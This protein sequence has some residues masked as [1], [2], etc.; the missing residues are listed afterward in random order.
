MGLFLSSTLK[1]KSKYYDELR[2]TDDKVEDEWQDEVKKTKVKTKKMKHSKKKKKKQINKFGGR[3]G[4]SSSS[5]SKTEQKQFSINTTD[6]KEMFELLERRP[7][8]AD[9]IVEKVSK[10][11]TLMM[12]TMVDS[13]KDFVS[14]MTGKDGFLR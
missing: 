10:N 3:R 8:I 7:G 4:G 5:H 9:L 13:N 6:N 1:T 2:A 12:K 11:L 14:T